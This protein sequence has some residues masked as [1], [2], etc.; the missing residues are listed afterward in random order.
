MT[1]PII[2]D[3]LAALKSR[4]AVAAKA[5]GRDPASIKLIAVSKTQPIEAVKAALTAGQKVFG[6]NRVQ[7]AKTKYSSFTSRTPPVRRSLGEGG[8]LEPRASSLE[9][10]LIGPL[11]TNKAEEAVKLFD[12]IQTL[13]RPK[14]AAALSAAMKK[15]SRSPR[16]YVEINIGSEPQKSGIPPEALENFLNLCRAKHSLKIEGL[17]CIPPQNVDPALYFQRLKQLADRHGLPHISIGMSADFEEAIR[18]GATEIRIGTA[19][20]GERKTPRMLNAEC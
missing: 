7:E 17:M 1:T 10:H 18:C 12:V 15:T 13:D 4:I 19:I 5:A 6:E 9:L 2:A 11:Q 14:L 20:F 3:N 8:S 16:L